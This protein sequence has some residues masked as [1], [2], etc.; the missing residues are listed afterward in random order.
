[1]AC[2]I[3]GLMNVITKTT[4]LAALCARLARHSYVAVDTEFMRETTFWP[5]LCLIQLAGPDEAACVDP[6]AP[7][8]DLQPFFALMADSAVL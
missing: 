6:L 1:M 2:D 7:G 3:P 4:D 8:L 5:K